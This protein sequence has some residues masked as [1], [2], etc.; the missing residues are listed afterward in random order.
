MLP[1]TTCFLGGSGER[2]FIVLT[3]MA[4][5]VSTDNQ[6]KASFTFTE[7]PAWNKEQLKGRQVTSPST[8]KPLHMP[9]LAEESKSQSLEKQVRPC[10]SHSGRFLTLHKRRK[11][12]PPTRAMTSDQALLDDLYHG[13]TH[14]DL[15][16][17]S[18]SIFSTITDSWHTFSLIL[19]K[20]GSFLV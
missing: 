10:W 18:V 15:C 1:F 3:D 17:R 14:D 19:S 5:T 16:R 6:S 2:K 4:V 8:S 13:P 7:R 20:S 11:K 9:D 12:R